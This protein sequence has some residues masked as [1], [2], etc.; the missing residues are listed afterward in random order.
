MFRRPEPDKDEADNPNAVTL[1]T[2][3]S[4]KM[5]SPSGESAD[6]INFTYYWKSDGGP[7]QLDAV[8]VESSTVEQPGKTGSSSPVG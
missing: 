1:E 4:V 7:W 8:A 6:A 2:N 5:V 3:A